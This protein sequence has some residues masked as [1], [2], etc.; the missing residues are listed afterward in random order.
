MLL[1]PP[2]ADIG[3]DAPLNVDPPGLRVTVYPVIEV[4]PVNAGA[5]NAT[6]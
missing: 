1:L 2:V 3:D 5:V 6:D 4:P